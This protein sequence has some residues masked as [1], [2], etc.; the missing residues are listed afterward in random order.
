MLSDTLDN[1]TLQFR[2]YH[3]QQWEKTFKTKTHVEDH[4]DLKQI[5]GHISLD[6]RLS[7]TKQPPWRAKP[8]CL[9]LKIEKK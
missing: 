3:F 5:D 7:S 1:I 6:S 8:G 9:L 4:V 2:S